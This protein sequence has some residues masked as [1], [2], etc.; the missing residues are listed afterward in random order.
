MDASGGAASLLD[1]LP[2]ASRVRN[3]CKPKRSK[4]I[5]IASHL[6]FLS[7]SFGQPT[8]RDPHISAFGRV[9]HCNS[10][11]FKP[12]TYSVL[13]RERWGCLKFGEPPNWGGFLLVS[14]QS[15]RKRSP[16]SAPGA[17]PETAIAEYGALQA[18]L[19]EAMGH[20]P[21][22]RSPYLQLVDWGCGLVAKG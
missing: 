8:V 13:R 14:R 5:T 10:C 3:A 22:D 4:A 2:R 20:R 19:T 21:V 9:N 17:S 12:T 6:L 16:A 11:P 15:I 7:R 18:K 1:V